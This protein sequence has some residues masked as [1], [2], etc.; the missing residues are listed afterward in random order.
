NSPAR[1]RFDFKQLL[2]FQPAT[3][4]KKQPSLADMTHTSPKCSADP[5][6]TYVPFTPPGSPPTA[7]PRVLKN[8]APHGLPGS[9]VL[10]ILLKISLFL[11]G[12]ATTP[13]GAVPF[14]AFSLFR[15]FRC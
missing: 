13:L 8:Q 14:A 7:L 10:L 11:S 2:F 5:A 3:I 6:G 12:R 1:S 15:V 4:S 9:V